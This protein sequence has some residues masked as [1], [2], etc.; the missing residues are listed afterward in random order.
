[1]E[2]TDKKGDRKIGTHLSW[3]LFI[4]RLTKIHSGGVV[5][6]AIFTAADNERCICIAK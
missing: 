3:T 4:T 6:D 1:M 2:T 5:T